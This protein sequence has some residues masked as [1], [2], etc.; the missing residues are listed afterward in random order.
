MTRHSTGSLQ[1]EN[2]KPQQ[3][4]K[5]KKRRIRRRKDAPRSPQRPKRRAKPRKL[6]PNLKIGSMHPAPPA[7]FNSEALADYFNSPRARWGHC[8]KLNRPAFPSKIYCKSGSFLVRCAVVCF[9]PFGDAD[10]SL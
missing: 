6:L 10:Q 8:E 9:M 3:P 1:S 2:Y 5:A 7:V 4:E